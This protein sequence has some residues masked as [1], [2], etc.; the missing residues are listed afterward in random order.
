MTKPGAG[1]RKVVAQV[2]PSGVVHIR[3]PRKVCAAKGKVHTRGPVEVGQVYRMPCD[4]RVLVDGLEP[5]Q[6][7]RPVNA[8]SRTP[9]KPPEAAPRSTTGRA[10][11][12]TP[13]LA[14]VGPLAGKRRAS[15]PD[16]NRPVGQSPLPDWLTPHLGE[17]GTFKPLPAVER[18]S[19]PGCERDTRL[20]SLCLSHYQVARRRWDPT[21]TKPKRSRKG[22]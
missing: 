4:M 11:P 15:N 17:L 2:T 20:A 22:H 18:C 6:P 1:Y 14:T 19:V 5:W 10:D 8:H 16:P 7:G 21:F 13:A 3:C 9:A 12:T